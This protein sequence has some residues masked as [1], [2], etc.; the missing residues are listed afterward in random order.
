MNRVLAAVLATAAFLAIA[1]TASA[2]V[3]SERISVS[4][5]VVSTCLASSSF[6]APGTQPTAASA[7]AVRC[8]SAWPITV[9]LNADS[10]AG[11]LLA[12]N[13]MKSAAALPGSVYAPAARLSAWA[14]R[15]GSIAA[16][17]VAFNPTGAMPTSTLSLGDSSPAAAAG[18]VTVTIS[19]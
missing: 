7:L 12:A 6:T 16:T 10:V 11:A 5:T 2:R 19:Y 17:S 18:V 15:S 1:G 13:L 9:T 14:D 3:L 4:A 8:S